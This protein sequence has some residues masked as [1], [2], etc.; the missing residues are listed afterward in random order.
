VLP[1]AFHIAP[2]RQAL[3]PSSCG[4]VGPGFVSEVE[5]R[6]FTLTGVQ[7]NEGGIPQDSVEND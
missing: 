1:W 2:G 3:Q 6:E 5:R 7:Q 4:I